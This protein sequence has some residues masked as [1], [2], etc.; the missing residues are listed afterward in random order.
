MGFRGAPGVT[1]AALLTAAM[2]I[3]EGMLVYTLIGT[4]WVECEFASEGSDVFYPV[5]FSPLVAPSTSFEA[6]NNTPYGLY[7]NFV[8]RTSGG[9]R[10]T[11][12]LFNVAQ[13]FMTANNRLTPGESVQLAPLL[14]TFNANSP[15]L[16]GIDQTN[17]TMKGYA[18]SG[19]N[20]KVAKKSRALV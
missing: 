4:S 8:G 16:T 2:P 20:D 15:V 5:A 11:W 6:N 1:S 19:I 12:Y 13:A 9:S 14:A 10:V 17:F 3:L 18:N 7:L